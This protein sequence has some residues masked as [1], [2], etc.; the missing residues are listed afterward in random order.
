MAGGFE[1]AAQFKMIVNFSVEHDA[2]LSGGV[3]HRLR[4]AVQ[5]DD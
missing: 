1:R 5:V 2:D 4:A 3:P